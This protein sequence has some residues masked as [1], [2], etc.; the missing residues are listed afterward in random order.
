MAEIDFS[1]LPVKRDDIDKA[2]K[3]FLVN[4]EPGFEITMVHPDGTENDFI[5]FILSDHDKMQGLLLNLAIA[6]TQ[7]H[8]GEDLVR[9]AIVNT[10]YGY[11]LK[12]EDHP[13]IPGSFVVSLPFEKDLFS[14]L[15][16]DPSLGLINS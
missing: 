1:N 16:S 2:L 9:E 6:V 11:A 13:E 12:I 7:S 10:F 14:A 8:L 4:E 5:Q 15:M 3:M